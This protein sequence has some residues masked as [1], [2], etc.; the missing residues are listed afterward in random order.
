MS[1]HFHVG[2]KVVCVND[3]WPEA[4]YRGQIFPPRVPML[5]EVLTI[6]SISPATLSAPWVHLTFQEIEH[7]QRVGDVSADVGYGSEH[8]RPVVE[9]K[10]DISIFTDM[11]T[12]TRVGV[13]A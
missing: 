7:C 4:V 3:E 6:V 13:R 11:L 8:F 2:Q 12:K 9:R 5:N 1:I 10:T